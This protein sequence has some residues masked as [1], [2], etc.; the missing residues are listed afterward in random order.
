[1]NLSMKK[2]F[3]SSFIIWLGLAFAACAYLFTIKDN[4]LVL[5]PDRIKFGID[6]VG[7]TYITLGVQ[8]DKAIEADLN[9]RI[10]LLIKKMQEAGLEAPLSQSYAQ[11]KAVLT[12]SS[13]DQAQ[14]AVQFIAGLEST[15]KMSVEDTKVVVNFSEH[16]AKEI[17]DAAVRGNIEVLRTRLDGLGVGEITIAPQGEKN[18]IV[19]L[20]N[21]DDPQK[22]K[23]MIGKPALLEIK[24]VE[25]IGSSED[26]IL[27][28]YDGELPEGM[29]IITGR[30]NESRL[31]REFYLVPEFTDLTG[32]L[33]KDSFVGFGGKTGGEVV[34]NF[35]FKPEGAERFYELTRKNYGRQVAIII[36]GV[37][38][39]APRIDT[40]IS[41][42]SGYIH[43]NFTQESA[44]E[45]AS[46]LKSG[47]FV[48][49]V[50]FEEER[51]IGP[52][53]GAESIHQ[54]LISCLV[55]LILLLIFSVVMYRIPG[56]FAFVTLL[57]N[58]LMIL[59]AL[60]WLGATLTLP[61]IAG[62]VLTVGMAI[63]CSI[64]IYERIREELSTGQTYAKAV[65]NGFS[66]AMEVILDANITT[67]VVGAVLYKF[68]SGPIQGFALTMM[69]GIISTLL[70][71]LFFLRSI[72]TFV[73][74]NLG[75]KSL[76]I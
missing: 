36:D 16:K 39:S 66:D 24:L 51:Q 52:S 18:I 11:E 43:G 14:L 31:G 47:A 19:E 15:L 6:L 48:A 59:V 10:Q 25:A 70:T 34:V 53:L 9:D 73:L 75:V 13:R 27:D 8:T 57:F 60:M 67:F 2:L 21:V 46:L 58:L 1:M 44:T 4:R 23:A 17:R 35:E 74:Y 71:G 7:G 26:D 55:G 33:L 28:K 56:F 5:R 37:V 76:K 30:G 50:T 68:G 38:I 32:R 65:Q 3:G 64:L 41:G 72:F 40:P 54:G 12:F 20:P 42:G 61:G 69:I 49:P 63:D 45:L 29:M 62:M 22:A